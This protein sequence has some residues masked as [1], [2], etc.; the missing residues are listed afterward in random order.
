M[1]GS[2]IMIG[3][4]EYNLKCVLCDNHANLKGS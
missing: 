1:T 3:K 2:N 4:E